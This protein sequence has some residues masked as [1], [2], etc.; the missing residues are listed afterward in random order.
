[1]YTVQP[2]PIKMDQLEPTALEYMVSYVAGKGI[3][4]YICGKNLS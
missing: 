4:G 1:M 3:R 2:I